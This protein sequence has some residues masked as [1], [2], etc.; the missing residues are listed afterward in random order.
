[1]GGV[2]IPEDSSRM[3][4]LGSGPKKETLKKLGKD[5]EGCRLIFV[6]DRVREALARETLN[7]N[8]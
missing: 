5:H 2:Q 4:A 3:Y 8:S 7:P 6:E 1:M